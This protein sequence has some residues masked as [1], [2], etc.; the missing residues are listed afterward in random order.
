MNG[1]VVDQAVKANPL[2]DFVTWAYKLPGVEKACLALQNRLKAD[3][4]IVL[5]CIWLSHRGAGTSNLFQNSKADF[6]SG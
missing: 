2:W 4:N 6:C 1:S 5:F 3:V